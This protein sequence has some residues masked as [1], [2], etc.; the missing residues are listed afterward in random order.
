[1]L[2]LNILHVLELKAAEINICLQYTNVVVLICVLIATLSFEP[3]L[4]A[5]N[6]ELEH[7]VNLKMQ[8]LIISLTLKQ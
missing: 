8:Q 6:P 3:I 5:L 4:L 7:V 1:M 2:N